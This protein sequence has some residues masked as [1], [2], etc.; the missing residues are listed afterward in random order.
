MTRRWFI[1]SLILLVLFL[2]VFQHSLASQ[3]FPL[4]Y[5]NPL[6][7]SKNIS[8]GTSITIRQGRAIDEASLKSDIFE[9]V[10]SKSGIH[11]GTLRLSDDQ[12]TI[13]FYPD[14]GFFYDEFV[15]ISIN[16][17]LRLGNG[18]AIRSE[19]CGRLLPCRVN[20]IEP[21]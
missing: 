7:G 21:C 11:T 1:T 16:E 20:S 12:L 5:I 14:R 18:A 19:S 2:S 4:I 6:P 3:T 9:V 13:L 8:P 15:D 17:G 10:G